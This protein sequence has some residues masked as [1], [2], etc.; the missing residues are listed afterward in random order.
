MNVGMVARLLYHH[1][2]LWKTRKGKKNLNKKTNMKCKVYD[3][4]KYN[5]REQEYNPSGVLLHHQHNSL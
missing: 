2:K 4:K 5:S 1:Q 3:K